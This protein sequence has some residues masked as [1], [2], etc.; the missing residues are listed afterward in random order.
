MPPLILQYRCLN[1]VSKY[2]HDLMLVVLCFYS[3]F[4]SLMSV[5][6]QRQGLSEVSTFKKRA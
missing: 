1:R 6:T 2:S 4:L 3:Y 5:L